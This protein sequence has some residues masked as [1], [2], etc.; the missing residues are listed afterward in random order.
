[1]RISPVAWFCGWI[2]AGGSFLPAQNLVSP[3]GVQGTKDNLDL[4]LDAA[5]DGPEEIEDPP[6]IVTFY[7]QNF[8]GDGIFYVVDRSSTMGDSGEIHVAKREVIRNIREF[9][10][11]VQFALVFF[12]ASVMKFP[13][14]G[15][16]AE[17]TPAMKASAIAYVESVTAG[18]G[19]CCQQALAAGLQF[20]NR[21]TSQRK[22][23]IYVGDGGGTCQGAD[24]STYLK[25]TL[26]AITSQNFQRVQINCIGVL[27][28]G[29][30]NEDFMKRLAAANGGTFTRIFR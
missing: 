16:P 12:D 24:E 2:L 26:A 29:P 21:A 15:L 30:L 5:V 11:R 28:Q 4:P 20:A 23:L 10:T 19:T 7:G 8:E 18:G 3:S 6:E 22:V 1:M 14:S 13:S 27:Q 17:C 25:Q 9:S